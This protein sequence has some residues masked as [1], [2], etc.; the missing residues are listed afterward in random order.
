M[1]AEPNLNSAKDKPLSGRTVAVHGSV[2]DVAFPIKAMPA[3]EE[4]IVIEA[5]SGPPVL[6]EVHQHLSP[7]LIRAVALENTA[8]LRRGSAVRATGAA[9]RVPVTEPAGPRKP[10]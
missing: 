8:G 10:R 5:E 6:A 2:I 3:I 1:T 7:N 4:A 9:L